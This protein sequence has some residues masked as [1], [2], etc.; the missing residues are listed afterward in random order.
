MRPQRARAEQSLLRMRLP[1]RSA[2][3]SDYRWKARQSAGP[4]MEGTWIGLDEAHDGGWE[5]EGRRRAFR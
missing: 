4:F 1:R 5:K 3:R 2:S